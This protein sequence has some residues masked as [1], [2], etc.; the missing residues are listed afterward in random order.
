M[1]Y[2]VLVEDDKDVAGVLCEAL[3]ADGHRCFVIRTKTGAERFFH[4]V[5]P[6]LVVMDCLLIGGDGLKLARELALRTD[7]PVIVTSGDSV[8]A[9]EAE[10]AG[11]PCFQK[12]F[13]LCELAAAVWSL[14][15]QK[16]SAAGSNTRHSGRAA[17]RT[18]GD[19]PASPG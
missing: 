8:R 12:P 3:R 5:R 14:L 4:R 16:E 18:D 9:E 15:A 7:V 1:A 19:A 13:R 10:Q 2:I 11:L 6:D 17:D